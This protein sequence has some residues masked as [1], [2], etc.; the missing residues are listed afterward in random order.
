MALQHDIFITG[1]EDA[2]IYI[3]STWYDVYGIQSIG[4]DPDILNSEVKGDL[5]TLD[6]YSKLQGTA[7]LTFKSAT[8]NF[9]L[10]AKLTGN[11][12]TETGT[13]PNIVATLD[14]MTNVNFPYFKFECDTKQIKTR[15]QVGT[16]P[17]DMHLILYVCQL[18]KFPFNIS[19]ENPEYVVSDW[20][21][22]VIT[23]TTNNKLFTYELRETAKTIGS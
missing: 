13:T 10:L 22:K 1:I 18:Q 14:G 4:F 2:K 16:L 11:N 23:D 12:I 21:A 20:S 9:D 5:T 19:G 15:G 17:A 8:C 3:N 6:S 7:T